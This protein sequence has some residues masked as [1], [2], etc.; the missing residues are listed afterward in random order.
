MALLRG[1]DQTAYFAR[2]NDPAQVHTQGAQFN[3]R[4]LSSPNIESSHFVINSSALLV[5]ITYLLTTHASLPC[6]VSKWSP[7]PHHFPHHVHSTPINNHLRSTG[8]SNKS[9]TASTSVCNN[10][11]NRTLSVNHN[12]VSPRR[13]S[14]ISLA[15]RQN[16]KLIKRLRK[17]LEAE[18][19]VI[20]VHVR[21]SRASSS[22]ASPDIVASSIGSGADGAGAVKDLAAGSS[23][24]LGEF[25]QGSGAG[26]GDEGEEAEELHLG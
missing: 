17:T 11:S 22:A 26:K 23:V 5:D 19:L 3:M 18:T 8:A 15:R 1:R 25:I 13:A 16:R 10:T 12:T 9:V 21:V 4:Q 20:I 6:L 7:L 2:P 14:S 24:S